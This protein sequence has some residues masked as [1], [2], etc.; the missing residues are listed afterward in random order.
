MNGS[1]GGWRLWLVF[2]ID[3]NVAFS[4]SWRLYFVN[5]RLFDFRITT[6]GRYALCSQL[7]TQLK[8]LE[9]TIDDVCNRCCYSTYLQNG[10]FHG[11]QKKRANKLT[12]TTPKQNSNKNGNYNRHSMRIVGIQMSWV[13]TKCVLCVC[14]C[15]LEQ[16]Q[17]VSLNNGPCLATVHTPAWTHMQWT[18]CCTWHSRYSQ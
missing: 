12:T 5:E 8:K 10:T 17:S 11:R 3:H 16:R 7:S 2:S 6:T 14:L 4:F 9:Y 13:C 18:K 1:V 15:A